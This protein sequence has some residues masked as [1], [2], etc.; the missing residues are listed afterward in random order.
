MER[1]LCVRHCAMRSSCIILEN[2]NNA[3]EVGGIFVFSRMRKMRPEEIH[4]SC[5]RWNVCVSPNSSVE[6]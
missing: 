4:Y 1:L 6:T 3:P 5:H 2:P